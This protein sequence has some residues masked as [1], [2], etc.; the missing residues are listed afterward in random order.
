M[1]GD[2]NSSIL[3][4][5]KTLKL[6]PRHFGA[7]DGLGLIFIDLREYENAMKVYNQLLKIFPYNNSIIKKRETILSLISKEI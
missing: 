1:I 5:E 7:L 2:Y 4:I 3:D 6:E